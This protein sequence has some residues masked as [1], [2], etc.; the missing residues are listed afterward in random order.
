MIEID[1]SY[2]EAGGQIIRTSVALSTVTGK[3][4]KITSIRANRKNPGLQRQHIAS[5][6]AVA[7]LCNAEIIG[8]ELNSLELEFTPHK[9]EGGTLELDIGSAGSIALV[10]QSIMLPAIH[11]ESPVNIKITG[12][13]INK[14]APSVSYIQNVTLPILKKMGY[15]GSIEIKKHGFFPAGGGVVEATFERVELKEIELVTRG[16]L[17]QISGEI[18]IS[19]DL[20][21]NKVAE[22]MNESANKTLLQTFQVTPKIKV[23]YVSTLSTGGGIDLFA[24]YENSSIGSN[25]IAEAGKKSEKVTREA[26]SELK[27]VDENGAPLDEYMADQILPF[28]ALSK[29]KVRVAKITSHCQTNMWV[30]EQFLDMKFG[31]DKK[32]RI[33]STG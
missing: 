2:G 16:K 5:I 33:I 11:S 1:G 4:C 10:L 8:N 14:W 21:G 28:L 12:G 27:K 9:I 13:T 7:K 24:T 22:R 32:K 3:P 23:N 29:G 17:L 26:V 30:I 20:Q 18:N 31:V 19:N 25:A 15:N 6:E